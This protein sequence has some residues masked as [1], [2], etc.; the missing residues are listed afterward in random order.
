MDTENVKTDKIQKLREGNQ[1]ILHN[2]VFVIEM[3][4]LIVLKVAELKL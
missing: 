3:F 4:T 2:Y 1:D